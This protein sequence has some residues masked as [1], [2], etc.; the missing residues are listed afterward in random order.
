MQMSTGSIYGNWQ[1][2]HKLEHLLKSLSTSYAFVVEYRQNIFYLRNLYF[3]FVYKTF[4]T[5]DQSQPVSVFIG[6]L[7]ISVV[8]NEL[9]C[10]N[11]H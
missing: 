11:I 10:E 4:K 5:A 7:F 8:L 2:L 6:R 9:Q 3:I 1:Q